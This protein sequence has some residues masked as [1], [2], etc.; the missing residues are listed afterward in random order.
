MISYYVIDAFYTI[1]ECPLLKYA[2]ELYLRLHLQS[3]KQLVSHPSY[4]NHSPGLKTVLMVKWTAA[5]KCC[6]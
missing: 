2:L 5:A 3:T 6:R 4:T 1:L